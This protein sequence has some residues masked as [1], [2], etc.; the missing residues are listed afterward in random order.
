MKQ[1]KFKDNFAFKI[2]LV[3]QKNSSKLMLTA[4]LINHN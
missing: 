4:V 3:I 2:K 1:S